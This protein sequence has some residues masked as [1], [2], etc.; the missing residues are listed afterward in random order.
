M[1]LT[2]LSVL[3][4]ANRGK[5]VSDLARI[6]AANLGVTG[7][8][9]MIR[10]VTVEPATPVSTHNG[11]LY[12]LQYPRRAATFLHTQNTSVIWR[13]INKMAASVP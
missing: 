13:V 2:V 6:L 9:L 3:S 7:T 1:T 10:Q 4:S 5:T 8:N 11:K 12:L